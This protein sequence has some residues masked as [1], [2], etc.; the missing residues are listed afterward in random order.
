MDWFRQFLSN[1]F[2][3]YFFSSFSFFLIKRFTN[4]NRSEQRFKHRQTPFLSP[5]FSNVQIQI[6]FSREKSSICIISSKMT[7]STI[8]ELMNG[9]ELKIR[10]HRA[11]ASDRNIERNYQWNIGNWRRRRR[12]RK[13]I[14]RWRRYISYTGW[15]NLSL[16]YN[17]TRANHIAIRGAIWPQYWRTS[18]FPLWL[19]STSN[20]IALIVHTGCRMY[21]IGFAFAPADRLIANIRGWFRADLVSRMD[22]LS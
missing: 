7:R 20:V 5:I 15:G 9:R 11:S 18:R 10:V 8:R 1:E 14:E 6:T 2:L 3:R 21:N 13:E 19:S 12:K 22:P 17:V 16:G 4:L